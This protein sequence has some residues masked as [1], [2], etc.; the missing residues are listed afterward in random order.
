MRRRSDVRTSQPEIPNVDG[1]CSPPAERT[2]VW[3]TTSRRTRHQGEE[4]LRK[5]RTARSVGGVS[6][7]PRTWAGFRSG[8]SSQRTCVRSQPSWSR[9]SRPSTT[10]AASCR[11]FHPSWKQPS[12]TSASHATP[13][14]GKK[15]RTVDLPPRKPR[16]RSVGGGG[17]QG[18]FPRA[19]AHLRLNHVG[20]RRVRRDPGSVARTF[21]TGDHP[22]L[23]CS[24]HAGGRQQR[25]RRHRR[26]AG[27]AG[28]PAR[29][30]KLPRFSPASLTGDPCPYAP[31]EPFVDCKDEE[32]GGLG[33]C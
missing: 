12:T 5:P 9:Q 15:V 24:L 23:L 14:K 21:L 16:N 6:I 3:P 1:C 27:G 2:P 11:S 19:S 20:S 4:V 29:R 18:R 31:E 22:R 25:A 33:Q 10:S 32:M 17:P 28:R 8:A 7:S 26:S 30:P 13:S